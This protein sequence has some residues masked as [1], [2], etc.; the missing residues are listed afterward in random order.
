MGLLFFFIQTLR[1]DVNWYFLRKKKKEIIV[2]V[3]KNIFAWTRRWRNTVNSICT[4]VSEQ[5]NQ[6]NP[7]RTDTGHESRQFLLTYL[8][9]NRL[10][11]HSYGDIRK[12]INTGALLLFIITVVCIRKKPPLPV[13]NQKNVIKHT[14]RVSPHEDL[15]FQSDG[16]QCK[17]HYSSVQ[18]YFKIGYSPLGISFLF[19]FFF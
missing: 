15:T 19:L 18:Q 1:S 7:I 9:R 2:V 10:F 13:W 4:L 14:A 3:L 17:H 5:D 16:V 6:G 8:P 11:L 12:S